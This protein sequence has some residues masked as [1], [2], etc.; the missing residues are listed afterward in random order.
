LFDGQC[1][2]RHC[3]A[4]RA[5]GQCA[6]PV[7]VDQPCETTAECAPG[8]YCN[9]R[10]ATPKCAAYPGPTD[11]DQPCVGGGCRRGLTCSYAKVCKPEATLGQSCQ[12][13]RS[14]GDRDVAY[15]ELDGLTCKALPGEN[16]ACGVDAF[17]G[18]AIYCAEGLV[19]IASSDRVGVCQPLQPAGQPCL[20]TLGAQPGYYGCA[21]RCDT[22]QS[23]PVCV[24]LYEAGMECSSSSQCVAGLECGCPAGGPPVGPCIDRCVTLR[25]LGETCGDGKT[26]CHPAYE[27]TSGVCAAKPLIDPYTAVCG[28]MP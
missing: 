28:P 12:E 3:T 8:A 9:D 22:T 11:L 2:S 16:E 27:C 13:E 1:A 7:A 19:C 18:L 14:C 5:C 26:A 20:K 4:D 10:V 24:D 23:P 15:C 21:V 17:V 25:Y 6:E